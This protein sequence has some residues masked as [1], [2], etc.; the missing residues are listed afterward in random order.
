VLP[1]RGADGKVPDRVGAEQ[2]LE[3]VGTFLHRN[4]GLRT[5]RPAAIERPALRAETAEHNLLAPPLTG[6]SATCQPGITWPSEYG[7]LEPALNP[8]SSRPHAPWWQ[9][10]VIYQIYPR[11]FQD[12]TGDGTGDLRGITRRIP[13]LRWLGVDAVWISPFYR[14]PMADFGYDVADHRDVDPCSARWRT[15]THWSTPRTTMASA[16]S[17][18]T[19]RTT[20]RTS[21][22]WFLESRRSRDSAKR[23]WYLWRDP[24]RG[25]GP[26]NNW[27]SNFGGPA[28]TFD[29]ATH[30]FYGHAYLPA[31][32]DLNWHDPEVRSAMLDVLRFWLDRGVD[33]FR[34]DALRQIGKDPALRDNPSNPRWREG[35]NPY[36][37]LMPEH[38]ADGPETLRWLSEM[39]RIADAAGDTVLVGELYLSLERLV[40]YYGTPDRPGCQIPANFHLISTPWEARAIDALSRR[41]ESLLPPHTW[42]NWVLGNHD[43]PRLASRVARPRPRS[44]RCCC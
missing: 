13:Y 11:S 35:D 10:G 38:S 27:L 31:Q 29:E 17:W 12:S 15:S 33:G 40:D 16:S 43:K 24:A 44:R 23:G 20:R 34:L 19:S 26:P 36:A 32:P 7:T 37:R 41:Y 5:R 6:R 42:P 30:Q 28:W 2:D 14:S 3:T 25:R 22:P 4:A 21:H 9:S 8:S 39:R 1:G 18:T